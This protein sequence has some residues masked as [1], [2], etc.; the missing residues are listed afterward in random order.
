M[1]SL[2]KNRPLS[3][4]NPMERR[5][6]SPSFPQMRESQKSPRKR[7]SSPFDSSPFN[8]SSPRIFWN[9]HEGNS[10]TRLGP[11]SPPILTDQSPSTTRRSSI[12]N[13]KKASRVK[14]S[15]MFAREHKNE[16]DPASTPQ[17]E[18]PLAAGR[19]FK[20]VMKENSFEQPPNNVPADFR[21]HRPSKSM[22][23]IPLSSPNR[24][25]G[26]TS[27]SGFRTDQQTH[28]Q[29][30]SLMSDNTESELQQMP[31]PR[32]R[33]RH[34]KSVTFDTEA[35]VINEY[36]EQTPEPSSVASGSR[37]SSYD[38]DEESEED[39]SFDRGSSVDQEDSFDESLEDTDKTPVVLPEDWRHMSP[40][41]ARTELV[42]PGD[43][44]FDSKDE[45]PLASPTKIQRPSN[46]LRSDSSNS[47][48]SRPLPPVPNPFSKGRR[49]SGG[50]SGTADRMSSFQRSLP[51]PPRPASVS[52]ADILG[53]RDGSLTLDDRFR[54]MELKEQDHFKGEQ[55]PVIE[56]AQ[57]QPDVVDASEKPH[58]GRTSD[59][60][61]PRISRESILR[62]VKS[63]DFHSDFGYS[64]PVGSEC[65]SPERSYGDLDDLDPDVPIP[66]REA[67]S[68]FD[69]QVPDPPAI[70]K[71]PSDSE[72]EIDVYAI[73][74]MYSEPP[75]ERP[76]QADDYARDSS[77]VHHKIMSEGEDDDQDGSRYSNDAALEKQDEASRISEEDGP[78]TPT[79][80]EFRKFQTTGDADNDEASEV[81]DMSEF[82]SYLN[83]Q[84]FDDR[85]K[86]FMGSSLSPDAE[87]DSSRHAQTLA[88]NLEYLKRNITPE[89]DETRAEELNPPK[90]AEEDRS[91]TPDSVV[92]HVVAD[93]SEPQ[94]VPEPIATIKSSGGS[95]LKTRHSA[96]PADMEV[97]AA[98]RRQVS[99][100]KP[101]PIPT[102]NEKRLSQL[103][104]FDW[105]DGRTGSAGSDGTQVSHQSGED[106]G[107]VSG[108]LDIPV[109]GFSDDLGLGLKQEFDRVIESQKVAYSKSLQQL[110]PVSATAESGPSN[111][112]FSY[113][114]KTTAEYIGGQPFCPQRNPT[115]RLTRSQKGY[116]MRQ[117]TKVVVASS[118]QF[119]DE[120]KNTPLQ[121][122]TSIGEAH[123]PT[124][125][126]SGT[127]SAGNS[128]R[129]ASQNKAW[130]T[131]P[132]NGKIRRKS[133][134][135]NSGNQKKAAL[136]A[137]PPL[138][139]QGSAI[140]KADL[141]TEQA[142]T[143]ET[144]EGVERGRLFV[145]VVGVK[146]LD[147]PLPRSERTQFQLT[148]DNGLHCVTT[149]WL[150]LGHAAPI[151]QEFELVVLNDLEFQLT[152]QTKLEPPAASAPTSLAPSSPS[153][154]IKPQKSSTFSRF[155]SSPKKRREAE[156]RAAE[157]AEAARK[158]EIENQRRT[159]SQK[160]PSAWELLHEL[161]A[162]DGS[163]ARAYVSLSNHV[164]QCYGRP[165]TVA[166]PCF[167]EWALETDPM[168]TNSVRS[169]QRG[170]GAGGVVRRPPY[171][172]GKLE[173]QL[174]YV[175]R[176][177]GTS[178]EDMPRSLGAAV[179]ELRE[180]ERDDGRKWEGFLSQQGGDCP[181]W[182][183][184]FFKL[185]AS[186]LT[187]FHEY[188]NQPR[189]TINLTKAACLIDD[190]SSLIQPVISPSSG[191]ST[192]SPVKGSTSPT[193]SKRRKSGFAEDEDGYMFVEEGFRIRFANGEVIDFYADNAQD[194]QGW[195][196]VLSEIVG[197]GE[198]QA[199]A[200]TGGVKKWCQIVL[201]KEKSE[202]R[203]G[204]EETRLG[205][206]SGVGENAVSEQGQAQAR[207]NSIQ[208]KQLPPNPPQPTPTLPSRPSPQPQLQP[209]QV[210]PAGNSHPQVQS[211]HA[212]T[213]SVPNSPVK[214]TSQLRPHSSMDPLP[215]PHMQPSSS[216]RTQAA[217]QA[218]AQ[219]Q[220][221]HY[222]HRE[223]E[224]ERE[225]IRARQAAMQ[226][227]SPTK[228]TPV[229]GKA[230]PG[231]MRVGGRFGG[232]KRD[233]VRSMIF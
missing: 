204:G 65:G 230:T 99:G 190:K 198:Q 112:I 32:A 184:R 225:Q 125:N 100:E 23:Q 41:A 14:N 141:S 146:D 177:R 22:S 17:I 31:T 208:R 96:T 9:S 33:V 110:S 147:L 175:P 7:E 118:R 183:R 64:S 155:L 168:I 15:N 163:F 121:P 83:H 62:K 50:L 61:V 59:V 115:H 49:D 73:P 85:V 69:E 19:P 199:S 88:A 217:Q 104:K 4:I 126:T 81:M 47:E 13:L 80:E 52:K 105:Q 166:V 154:S 218:Q 212:R 201:A 5:R 70:K 3:E 37:A 116:L 160:E 97:L 11:M 63:R 231:R 129:K 42:E 119:S 209:Q 152:L 180:A 109:G 107:N 113:H 164:G 103:C 48:E 224:K 232:A 161:V 44:V 35:P 233:G 149:S 55:S 108:M 137:A 128:P 98:Y 6:N 214:Q 71:E 95:K 74:D 25:P 140:G 135:V 142:L 66:S 202:G 114:P 229:A 67:S 106:V 30:S 93:E 219:A 77:V 117:N 174:L 223:R 228:G 148:L 122:R 111:P 222:Q 87:H 145:K 24:S 131:E 12:E 133:L 158:Q 215:I 176:V 27:A 75:E 221:A 195:M 143:E 78:P 200:G 8:P 196:R 39:Y 197:K 136:A 76:D 57:D 178:E 203:K 51:T 16:Y 213:K 205:S 167:N 60:G 89:E 156:Q 159:A 45:S 79:Q 211:N 2:R 58:E 207:T 192:S 132:W 150:E 186:K 139:G 94:E 91:D 162:Q 191:T 127:R 187:A 170:M 34:A 171:K 92:H 206:G 90:P 226:A 181:F 40:L 185:S 21:L 179:R 29:E 20:T 157:E 189:A 173:L 53:M 1:D 46:L 56:Q 28:E 188:T 68:N 86:T 18:R 172:V 102:R 210:G 220:A 26:R 38:I 10:P 169:K 72:S 182:R 82:E 138:P 153:K 134:R 151:G 123:V 194:K 84:S 124:S 193:K 227:A 101:P 216:T 144:E 54:L 36:E 165:F 130:A 120:K 43:D